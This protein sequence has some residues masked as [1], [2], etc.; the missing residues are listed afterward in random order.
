[1]SVE[2]IAV[3]SDVADLRRRLRAD[4]SSLLDKYTSRVEAIERGRPGLWLGQ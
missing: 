3:L 1:M 2:R 4:E